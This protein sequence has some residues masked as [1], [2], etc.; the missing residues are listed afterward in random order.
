MREIKF[1]Y[2]WKGDWYYIDLYND[3]TKA[4]FE[5]Y[6][7][8]N[9]TSPFCQFTGLLDKEGVEIYE[10]DIL[11]TFPILASDK[12]GD[13]SFNVEVKWGECGWL[14]N[15]SLGHYQARIS[16]II[17]NIHENPELLK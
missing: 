14:S 3:N 11:K 6:E 4:E 7:S 13:K 16:E 17:G 1:R 9:K 8:V 15:G 12:I 5:F 10:G 2:L